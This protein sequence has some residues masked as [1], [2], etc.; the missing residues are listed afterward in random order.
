[1][2]AGCRLCALPSSLVFPLTPPRPG[3]SRSPPPP[4]PPPLLPRSSPPCR[5]F[6]ARDDRQKA[7]LM[8]LVEAMGVDA[9]R[10][11]IEERMGQTLRR[12]V[13]GSGGGLCG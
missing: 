9:F 8:W 12:E 4:L 6:G 13:S 2:T 5:D 1:M 10:A 7:R 11:A 3:C